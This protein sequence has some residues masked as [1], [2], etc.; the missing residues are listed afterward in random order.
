MSAL[1]P[2][3]TRAASFTVLF[4][5][6]AKQSGR[7]TTCGRRPPKSGR[8]GFTPDRAGLGG[9]V[10]IAALAPSRADDPSFHSIWWATFCA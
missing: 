7:P 9:V 4:G 5:C 2:P 3:P 6:F 8:N 10:D 1:S